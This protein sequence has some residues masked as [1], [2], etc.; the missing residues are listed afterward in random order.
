LHERGSNRNGSRN[1]IKIVALLRYTV[2]THSIQAVYRYIM[3]IMNDPTA[4]D[5][6]FHLQIVSQLFIYTQLSELTS[7]HEL[8]LPSSKSILRVCLRRQL[9]GFRAPKNTYETMANDMLQPNMAEITIHNFLSK[10]MYKI[11][12]TYS[13]TLLFARIS[14]SIVSCFLFDL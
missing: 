11:R 13:S 12:G 4:S 3:M 8:L 1:T 10:P 5:K 9:N 14:K 6:Q 2:L 7:L